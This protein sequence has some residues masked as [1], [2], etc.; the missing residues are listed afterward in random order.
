MEKN[1][2]RAGII[3]ELKC[4][5]GERVTETQEILKEIKDYM[6][7]YLKRKDWI[8]RDFLEGRIKIRLDGNDKKL[9]EKEIE[10]EEIEEAIMQLNNG[11]SPGRDGIPN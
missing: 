4:K 2:Q 1:R 8:K 3:K 7:I 5:D 9:C 11:K 6:K 10:N